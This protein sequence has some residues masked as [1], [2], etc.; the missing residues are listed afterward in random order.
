MCF[1]GKD[2]RVCPGLPVGF[3][4]KKE[5]VLLLCVSGLFFPVWWFFVFI[6]FFFSYKNVVRKFSSLREKQSKS[7]D[8]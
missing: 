2:G 5:K 7:R 3:W 4:G 8:W 1:L 6:F